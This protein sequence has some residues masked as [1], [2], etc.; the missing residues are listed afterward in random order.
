MS[1]GPKLKGYACLD[2]GQVWF[3]TDPRDL[4]DFVRKHCDQRIDE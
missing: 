1:Y 2:C 4:E 3:L